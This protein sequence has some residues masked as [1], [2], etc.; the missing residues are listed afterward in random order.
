MKRKLEAFGAG[1][2]DTDEA[3]RLQG[4]VQRLREEV[5]SLREQL[6]RPATP[7]RFTNPI[8]GATNLQVAC[9]VV[10]L[11]RHSPQLLRK[12]NCLNGRLNT[13]TIICKKNCRD[14]YQMLPKNVVDLKF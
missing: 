6:K 10:L 14:Y 3:E 7:T 1:G 4:E 5:T 11:V 9:V 2:D 12:N 13:L 8:G